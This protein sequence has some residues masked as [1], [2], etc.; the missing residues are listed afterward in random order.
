LQEFFIKMSLSLLTHWLVSNY[1]GQQSNVLSTFMSQLQ[2]TSSIRNDACWYVIHTHA[3]Q[4]LRAEKNLTM[5]GLETFN[6]KLKD[7]RSSSILQNSLYMVKS[8]F[9]GYIFAR[10]NADLMLRKIC[11]TRGVRKVVCYNGS[12]VPVADEIIDLIKSRVEDD[13]F[14]RI[15][16]SLRCGDKVIVLNG[17]LSDLVGIFEKDLNDSDRVVVLL[18][19][20]NYQSRIVIERE[21]VRKV[22]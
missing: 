12:P 21:L 9:P 16:P 8:L 17:P 14:V 15:R 2:I 7:R 5:W 6:P 11:F 1:R 18:T 3:L 22:C 19:T 20:L 4:E 10:F 13:G